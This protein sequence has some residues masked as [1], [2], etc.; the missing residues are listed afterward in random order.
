M[1]SV[2]L[3]FSLAMVAAAMLLA[4]CDRQP[5]SAA[6]DPEVQ[7]SASPETSTAEQAP[8]RQ[9]QAN[10]AAQS[11]R[12]GL[13]EPR[14]EIIFSCR[15]E[16]GKTASVCGTN[17]GTGAGA[18]Q[19]RYGQAAQ[20][21]ELTWP[22]ADSADGLSFASVPYSGGGE[23]QLQFR[24][25]DHQYIVYSRVIRT[26]FKAGEP[27]DP[28]M[29]DGVIVRRVDKIVARH[30]CADPGVRSIDYEKA[31]RYAQGLADDIVDLDFQP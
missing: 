28:A 27:N 18:A 29:Q 4:G 2:S 22:D 25:G 13:C 16:N 7:S 9:D 6:L 26:S 5:P 17:M 10:N 12:I 23:A 3:P 30:A 14:E 21:P 8:G 24:R 15:L 20:R 19:Y 1:K 31:R 11:T